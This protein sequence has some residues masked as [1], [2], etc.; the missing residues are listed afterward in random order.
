LEVRSAGI[1]TLTKGNGGAGNINISANSFLVEGAGINTYTDKN[2]QENAGDINIRVADSFIIKDSGIQ[3]DSS[4]SNAGNISISANSLQ[5]ENTGMFSRT[6]NTGKSGGNINIQVAGS[7]VS[8]G[9]TIANDTYGVGNAGK[10]NISANV[11][12]MDDSR[13][14]SGTGINA[15]GNGGEINIQ[16]NR[17][18]LRNRS[19]I[20]TEAE[21]SGKGNAGNIS[22]VTDTIQLDAQSEINAKTTTGQGGNI[23]LEIGNLLLLRRGSFIS[24]TAG[25]AQQSGDG[26]NITIN[27]PSGFIVAV[28]GEN[29]DITANA[30]TGQGGRIN[31]NSLGIFNFTQRS[32]EDLVGELGTDNPNLLDTQKLVTNDITAFSLTNQ[33]LSGQVTINTPDFDPS[34]GLLELPI[35]LTD[36]LNLI[37]G[38]SCDAIASTDSDT[39][40]SKFTITGRGGLPPSPYEP[41]SSDVLW[42]DNRIPNIASQQRLEKPSTKP[43]SKDDAVKIVPAT[44]WVFDG[45]GNVTLISHTSN[46]NLGSTPACQNK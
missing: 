4:N 41:L 24:A 28:R 31:I 12:Q 23:G 38:T 21:V 16:A 5:F 1:E 36:T 15:T 32:R 42:S 11:L 18:D 2:S 30:Y 19:F 22:I 10:L 29:S 27:A 35:V 14:R 39:D 25:T 44:G 7:F 33:N 26:G 40:K 45:K 17:I 13:I 9:T 6:I 3:T 34:K 20:N 8:K 37:A 46:A 43:P